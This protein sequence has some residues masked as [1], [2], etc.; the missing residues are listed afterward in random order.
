MTTHLLRDYLTQNVTTGNR[1]FIYA[2]LLAIFLRRIL[3]YSYVGDTN[4]PINTVG[5]LLI[6]TADTTPTAPLPTFPAGTKAGINLGA[7]KEFYVSIPA[8]VRVVNSADVG[9]ILVLRSTAFPTFNS[10]CFV[11]LGF[12]VSTN[13]YIID[14]RT[15]GDKPPVE[16][17]DSLEW[18]IYEKDINCPTSGGTDSKTSAEYRSDGTSN[19][20]RIILQ[21]PHSLAW[22]VRICN[23]GS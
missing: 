19:T 13:A 16:A 2:Y 10:G 23:E 1:T 5:S 12:E 22:Q 14:Y 11:I 7:Q 20:P 17:A 6:A 21:S 18:Y 4:Y 3:R 9:R 8:S 15:L